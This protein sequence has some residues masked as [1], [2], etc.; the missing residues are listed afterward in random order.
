MARPAA[1]VSENRPH[2][3][4][5]LTSRALESEAWAGSLHGLFDTEWWEVVHT[6]VIV[7]EQPDKDEPNAEK[8]VLVQGQLVNVKAKRAKDRDGDDWLMLSPWEFE[9]TCAWELR[10]GIQSKSGNPVGYVLVDGA[11]LGL[12][13]QL[14]GPLPSHAWPAS[15]WFAVSHTL[16]FVKEFPTKVEPN[17]NLGLLEKGQK[18]RVLPHRSLDKDG[19]HWAEISAHEL[20]RLFGNKLGKQSDGSPAT[21]GFV[22]IDGKRLN[23]PKLLEGPLGSEQQPESDVAVRAGLRWQA[24]SVFQPP[25][26]VEEPLCRW[27]PHTAAGAAPGAAHRWQLGL[28]FGGGSGNGFGGAQARMQR[29]CAACVVRGAG[30][31]TVLTWI[32]YHF[33][34]KFE[35]L[36]LFFDDPQDSAAEVAEQF[37]RENDGI[38]SKP[39]S[40]ATV[41]HR[42]MPSWWSEMERHSRFYLARNSWGYATVFEHETRQSIAARQQLCVDLAAQEAAE[43][44]FDWIL[45]LDVN[46]LLYFPQETHRENAPEWFAKV[47]DRV[48][49]VRFLNHECVPEAMELQDRFRDASLF[50]VNPEFLKP[51]EEMQGEWR[52]NTPCQSSDSEVDVDEDWKRMR[53]IRKQRLP[54]KSV[55]AMVN[56]YKERMH[57][58]RQLQLQLPAGDSSV[59]VQAWVSAGKGEAFVANA[60]I[61][62]QLLHFVG[63]TSGKAA[64]RLQNGQEPPILS[65]A[66]RFEGLEQGARHTVALVRRRADGDADPVVLQYGTCC[67]S[68]WLQSYQSASVSEDD[69]RDV[70]EP[71]GHRAA[72]TLATRGDDRLAAGQLELFYRLYV[73]GNEF[74]ELPWMYCRGLVVRCT[75]VRNVVEA[76][77]AEHKAADK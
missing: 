74:G 56:V 55:A 3:A 37:M 66:A 62:D 22:L 61:P 68:S 15:E 52:D 21:R 29:L 31:E 19:D 54:G 33:R 39:G 69:L 2:R 49:M 16:V 70:G 65:S 71:V 75:G 60:C 27:I 23:L 50:K 47:P 76:A 72:K 12:P 17:T 24:E 11:K 5:V 41:V 34:L 1:K 13:V 59:D 7:K 43:D 10:E 36:Y 58:A 57:K 53:R 77:Y 6:K 46:E 48:D 64:A 45:H 63:S 18:L 30:P 40:P 14:R 20:Q 32:L 51:W 35:R 73:L 9:R 38:R 44:G 26:S 42:M 8:G 67:Y 4:P 25:K 28:G